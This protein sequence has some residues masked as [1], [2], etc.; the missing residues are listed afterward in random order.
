M[1]GRWGRVVGRGG[2][3]GFVFWDGFFFFVGEEY[4]AFVKSDGIEDVAEPV[5]ILCDGGFAALDVVGDRD[6]G[7][8]FAKD[9]CVSWGEHAAQFVL[10]GVL[11]VFG[12]FFAAEFGPTV[13]RQIVDDPAEIE[14]VDG[15]FE[16]GGQG[17]QVEIERFAGLVSVVGIGGEC[18]VDDGQEFGGNVGADLAQVWDAACLDGLEGVEVGVALEKTASC[19]H[20]PQADADG[21]D[22]ASGGDVGG[23]SRAFGGNVGELALDHAFRGGDVVATCI[24]ESEVGHFDLAVSSD[25]DVWRRDVV[26][27]EA[28]GAAL[29][30]GEGVCIAESGADLQGD[31]DGHADGK[32]R[33]FF[34]QFFHDRLKVEAFD[35]FHDDE[36]RIGG[37]ADVIHADDVVVLQLEGQSRL[38]DEHLLEEFALFLD[39][40]WENAFDGHFSSQTTDGVHPPQKDLGHPSTAKGA[41]EFKPLFLWH[42]RSPEIPHLL[43][44]RLDRRQDGVLTHFV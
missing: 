5:G 18:L 37:L 26:V 29:S 8:D 3:I 41:D 31:V 38:V 24:R 16:E 32:N 21:E 34:A 17:G 25:Q 39:E 7:D 10:E 2:G 4:L 9:F 35:V 28:E 36:K 14:S 43:K 22:V 15:D 19:E 30:V 1:V 20:F 6:A 40:F 12:D 13:A 23:I 42:F 44:F 27:D 33:V 11:D